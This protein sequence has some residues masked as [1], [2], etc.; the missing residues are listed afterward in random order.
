MGGRTKA[1]LLAGG[2]GTRLRPLTNTV[3]KCLIPV[4]GK[5]MLSYWYD[6]LEAAGINAA[7]L[8][9]H[10]LR[11]QV[12]DHIATTNQTREIQIT[13]AWEPELLGSAGTVTA[14]RDWADGADE[15]V[16]IYADNLSDVD[17]GA[18]VAFHR[19]HGDP[20]TMLLFRTE[21][22]KQ[23]GIATLEADG[24]ITEFVEKPED[25]KSDLAN[26]GLYVVSAE[27]WR[28]IADLGGFDFGFDVIPRFVGR[29]RGY[30]HPGYHRDIGNPEALE[31]ANQDALKVFGS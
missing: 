12:V 27:A 5:P 26:A 1:L 25:P 23:C 17:L 8:N 4:A 18:F 21:Y 9:T 6:A 22:P 11:D 30:E 20:M 16:I 2:L 13:E 19:A 14:N 15:I 3:P 24:R 31:K 28:E 7:L 29:M 10:H